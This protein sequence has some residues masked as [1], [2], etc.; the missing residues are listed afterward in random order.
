MLVRHFVRVHEMLRAPA[1]FCVSVLHA[2][3]RM[4]LVTFDP[5]QPNLSRTGAERRLQNISRSA[6]AQLCTDQRD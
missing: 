1:R 3:A 6:L 2:Q 4:N 5:H